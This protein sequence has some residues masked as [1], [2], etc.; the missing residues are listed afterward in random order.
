MRTYKLN[1]P[2]PSLALIARWNCV[3]NRRKAIDVFTGLALGLLADGTVNSKEALFLNEWIDV[4]RGELPPQL[5]ANLSSKLEILS[6]SE[7]LHETDLTVLAEILIESIGFHSDKVEAEQ[8]GRPSG[9]IFDDISASD[10]CFIDSIFVLSGTF[11]QGSKSE[12]SEVIEKL[13]GFPSTS[14]PNK[15]TNYVV[16]G[17]KGSSQWVTSSLGSKIRRALDLKKDGL[18]IHIISEEVFWKAIEITQ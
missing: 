6:K 8:V 13:G 14:T 9:L 2:E 4:N 12:V 7:D 18:K 15:K 10:I 1:T 5:V 16:V 3:N 17:G 11:E